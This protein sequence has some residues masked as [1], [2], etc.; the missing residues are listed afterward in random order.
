M[1]FDTTPE[2]ARVRWEALAALDG[3]ERLA[4]ALALSE[5]TLALQ[6]EGARAREYAATDRKGESG[7]I[8]VDHRDDR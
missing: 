1:A 8:E 5:F 7:D 6:R 2:A 3:G 4:Q